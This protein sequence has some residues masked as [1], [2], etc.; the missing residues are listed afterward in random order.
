MMNNGKH[1]LLTTMTSSND[2]L[3]K[4]SNVVD[5]K[6]G[7]FNCKLLEKFVNLLIFKKKII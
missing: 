1:I 4:I 5:F 7:S 3:F 2:H 6:L